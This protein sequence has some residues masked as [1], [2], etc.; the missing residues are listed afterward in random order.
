MSGEPVTVAMFK[1]WTDASLDE[2]KGIRAEQ[3]ETN[4]LLREEIITTKAILNQHIKEYSETKVVNDKK[5]D[6]IFTVLRSGEGVFKAAKLIKWG[7]AILLAGSLTA[8]GAS[9]WNAYAPKN[10]AKIEVKT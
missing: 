10:P 4:V 5:F 7:V 2:M 8:A 6:R 9:I 3:S 1:I